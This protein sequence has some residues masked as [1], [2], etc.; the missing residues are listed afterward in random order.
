MSARVIIGIVS[1]S[2]FMTGLFVANLLVTIL[3]GEIN[4]K[5]QDDNLVSYWGFTPPKMTRIFSEYRRLYPDGRLNVYVWTAFA[6][7]MIGL[8]SAGVCLGILGPP[9]PPSRP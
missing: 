4:R 9:A 5:R 1:F 3:I 8:V 6:I 2:I 7:A